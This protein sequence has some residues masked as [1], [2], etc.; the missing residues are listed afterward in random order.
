MKRSGFKMKGM[1]FGNS[2]MK[3]DKKAKVTPQKTEEKFRL[4]AG[5]QVKG[6]PRDYFKLYS[7]GKKVK[8][9]EEQYNSYFPKK[10]KML[11][12]SMKKAK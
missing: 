10:K 3:Q 2:P 4:M 1:S 12:D 11:K 5:Q 7:D 8:I 9:T 6:G